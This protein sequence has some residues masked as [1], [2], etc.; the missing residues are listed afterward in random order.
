MHIKQLEELEYLG[1][2]M[3][4]QGKQYSYALNY[5]GQGE[6]GGRCYLNLTPVEEIRRLSEGA[7][8]HR[9]TAE[10]ESPATPA[11]L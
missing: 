8:G 4:A 7:G 9:A 10:A 3:G 11:S 1:V 2:R 6:E 5:R